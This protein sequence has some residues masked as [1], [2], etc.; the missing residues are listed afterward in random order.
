MFIDTGTLLVIIGIYSLVRVIADELGH[1]GD[2]LDHTIDKFFEND[3][4]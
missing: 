2:E 3:E 4:W 1:S